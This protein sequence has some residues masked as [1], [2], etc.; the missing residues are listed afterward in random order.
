MSDTQTMRPDEQGYNGWSNYPTWAV[1]LWLDN[2]PGTYEESR[3][4]VRDALESRALRIDADDA[5]RE[6]VRE[7][8]ELD[9]ASL[10]ADLLGFAL[11][12]V[13][14]REITDALLDD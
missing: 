5:L 12:S 10:R 13:D 4:I 3:A 6:Y 14:W 9:E 1:A 8:V 11:D 7:M 2:D